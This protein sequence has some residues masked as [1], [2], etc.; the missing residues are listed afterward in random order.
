MAP[1]KKLGEI[2]VEKGIITTKTV[3]RMLS[4]AQRQGKRFG[5][6]LEDLELVSGEEI[7]EALAEQ[8]GVR[9]VHNLTQYSYPPEVLQL[10]TA[11]LAVENGLFPL[12]IDNGRLAVALADP[13]D[14][15]IAGN[16]AANNQ[17]TVYPYVATRKEI[18]AAICKF[19]LGKEVD[20]S[21]QPT[22]LVVEDDKLIATMLH[23]ILT[24]Q[25]Y[26]VITAAD[27][28]EAFKEVI[29]HKPQVVVT[30]KEMPKLDGFGLFDAMQKI[31]ETRFIPVILL[32]GRTSSEDE[33]H[34]FDKGFFDF[35]VKPITAAT[36]ATRVRR[37]VQFYEH[38][39]YYPA[40][41]RE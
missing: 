22:I 12:K 38:K 41:H 36:I 24:R 33:T 35:I 4:I 32:T 1:R 40:T 19:Y 29:A 39:Y 31:P 5:T 9:V 18:H 13:T 3:E 6:V 20:N 14:T 11:D 23:D 21:K 10:V 17:L 27:G 8:H 7:A 16:I 34:A 28:M 15:R 26:H 2:F 37:A 30:D 25:G